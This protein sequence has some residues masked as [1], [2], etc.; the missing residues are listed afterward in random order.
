MKIGFIGGGALGLLFAALCSEHLTVTLM[1]RRQE[2]ADIIQQQGILYQ[3]GSEERVFFPDTI[4]MDTAIAEA[5]LENPIEKWDCLFLM[6]KQF[7]VDDRLLQ[8]LGQLVT[9]QTKLI[10]FQNG[11]GHR[12]KL[13]SLLDLQHL[14]LA[15]TTEAA[16]KQGERIVLHTGRGITRWGSA[17][18]DTINVSVIEKV[19]PEWINI[20][21][22][23]GFK[24]KMS[25][26]LNSVIWNKLLIN[27]VINPLTAILRVK[28]GQLLQSQAIIHLM[29]SLLEEGIR[30]AERQ[31]I[32]TDPKLWEQLL[33][34]CKQTAEN[35]SSMLQDIK[36]GNGNK[37]ESGSGRRT[38]IDS[39]N[40]SLI[41][42]SKQLDVKIPVH[43]AVYQLIKGI[44]AGG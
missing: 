19:G 25:K 43:E 30:V 5:A 29:K 24:T 31:G 20:L 28:N 34:V 22:N 4:S 23:A 11:I 9:S 15:V 37:S 14:Q 8:Q 26:N 21:N 17:Q 35:E 39:I 13:S 42:L 44:E 2:Q 18:G 38:E 1:T 27:S 12:E 6:V 40:G 3:C 36:H 32:P 16:K 7:H 10:C 41:K 33:E